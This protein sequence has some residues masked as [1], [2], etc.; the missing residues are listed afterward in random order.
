MKL[1][2]LSLLALVVTIAF[3]TWLPFG[4]YINREMVEA[5]VSVAVVRVPLATAALFITLRALDYVARI[6]FKREWVGLDNAKALYLS[7]R[8]VGVCILLAAVF[9]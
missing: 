8:F 2:L 6:N 5:S 1:S 4:G 9:G 3:I 7:A